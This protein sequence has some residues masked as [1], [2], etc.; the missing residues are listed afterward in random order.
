MEIDKVE[1][2]FGYML[3]AY[4]IG[5]PYMHLISLLGILVLVVAV[6]KIFEVFSKGKVNFKLL[7]LIL[8]AGS[9]A[10]VLGMLSQ[11]IGIVE[12]LEAIRAATDISPQIV[13]RGAIVSF[14]APIW[15]FIVFVFSLPIYFGLR[16]MVKAKLPETKS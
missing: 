13:M 11:I 7:G 5:G 8:M 4:K 12:A 9:M 3:Q 2:G 16:E 1:S 15:G 10:A 14:Y 6:W